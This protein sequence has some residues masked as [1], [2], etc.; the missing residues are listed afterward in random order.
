[1]A[2]E[3]AS[4]GYIT[5]RSVMELE[6]RSTFLLVDVAHRHRSNF[7]RCKQGKRSVQDYV[8]ELHNPHRP[9]PVKRLVWG[10]SP[11]GRSWNWSYA[12]PSSLSMW[13]IVTAPISC[14]ASKA[15]GRF[16]TTS[17]NSITRIGHGP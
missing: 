5:S 12:P 14:D 6:L 8:M 9:W 3:T 2:R 4:L 13:R 15:S 17:W 10:T 7:L 11:R 16:K 1:M